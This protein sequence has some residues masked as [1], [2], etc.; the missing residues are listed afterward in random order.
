MR[1]DPKD[2]AEAFG[3]TDQLTRYPIF[4]S[5]CLLKEECP[6]EEQ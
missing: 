2:V 4:S 1:Q 6:I 5:S 3:M